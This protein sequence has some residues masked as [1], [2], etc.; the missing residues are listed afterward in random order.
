MTKVLIVYTSSF[1]NTKRM[2][3]AITN[4]ARSVEGT[5]VICKEA[6]EATAD[7]VRVADA[8]V[9]GSPVR[10]RT[11]DARVKKFIEEVCEKLWL[12]D[13]M[14]GKV[15]GVFTVG[16]GYGDCGAGSELAQL[17]LLAGLKQILSPNKA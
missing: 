11:A 5:E 8:I 14:V 15:G 13:E 12:T 10:H 2:A 9:M 4:G 17:G 1:G 16:G 6:S 3:E 7:D